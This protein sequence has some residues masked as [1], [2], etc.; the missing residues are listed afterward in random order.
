MVEHDTRENKL[1]MRVSMSPFSMKI[2]PEAALLH[3]NFTTHD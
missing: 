3:R 2:P 1:L